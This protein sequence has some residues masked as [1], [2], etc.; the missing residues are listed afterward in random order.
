[1]SLTVSEKVIGVAV[2]VLLSI[3]LFFLAET[4]GIRAFTGN[5]DSLQY[6]TLGENFLAGHGFSLRDSPP[7]VLTAIRTPGYP[8]FLAFSKVVSGNYGV[9]LFLQIV[10]YAGIVVLTYKISMIL[11]EKK[12]LALWAAIL[13]F[14]D[15]DFI[16][17]ALSLLS[18]TL[19]TFFMTA[20]V[21]SFLLF[22]RSDSRR[23][24]L[25]SFFFLGISALVRPTSLFLLPIYIVFVGLQWLKN[26]SRRISSLLFNLGSGLFIVSIIL[27]PWSLRN[28][29]V[30]GTLRTNSGDTPTLYPTLASQIIAFRDDTSQHEERL[31]LLKRLE[32]EEREPRLDLK[33]FSNPPLRG[34]ILGFETFQYHDWMTEEFKKILATAPG[35]Y[36]KVVAFSTLD[37][38]TRPFWLTA[39][40]HWGVIENL[41]F[42]SVSYQQAFLHGGVPGLLSELKSRLDCGLKCVTA[43]GSTWVGRVYL[44][45]V[46]L[47][48]LAGV[49]GFYRLK[50]DYRYI[51]GFLFLAVF[52]F[53][54]M[55]IALQ[56][57]GVQPRY[58]MPIAPFMI[59]FA[60][61]GVAL[62]KERVLKNA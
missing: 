45:M 16:Y 36:V 42:P 6:I 21:F 56:G 53:A 25:G 26:D 10:A 33:S 37:Y 58:R 15:L 7:Y 31:A 34:E 8:L 1:M 50:K 41:E 52:S 2:I 27:A 13:M 29:A 32:A 35:A 19:F 39:L 4:I 40:L 17:N 43:F 55:H 9:A 54:V 48:S 22:L 51:T 18:D 3:L 23:P 5:R 24:I 20:S 46:S 28:F 61:Y 12:A 14:V 62:M 38:F 60:L 59:S 57:S 49:V 30:F 47:F 11:F 44:A